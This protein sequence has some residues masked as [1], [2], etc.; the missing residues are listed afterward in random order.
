[1][2]GIT[3]K[4]YLDSKRVSLLKSQLKEG[5]PV[6]YAMYEAGY[7][8]SSRLY[9]KSSAQLGMTPAV[10]RK[11][12]DGMKIRFAI[13]DSPLGKLL[14]AATEIGICSVSL[15]DSEMALEHSLRQEY[16]EATIVR[17][18]NKLAPWI[19]SIV[20]HMKGIRTDL[21]LP[22]EVIGTAFQRRVWEE[23]RKIPLGE[24]RTYT[25]IA[26]AIG[27]PKAVRAV[28][29][30][31]GA[32]HAAIVIPCHRVVRNDGSLG[33]YKWGIERKEKLIA[34]ERK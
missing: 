22:L 15:G 18:Q 27:N 3:P 31:C 21:D 29:N 7:G 30:A 12:G 19:H 33:G 24:T 16:S 11:N 20:Q 8:S 25:Q 10:Y 17:D 34:S 14:V 28:A 23:L 2:L 1:V 32:N 5:K 6:S 4:Q 13:T 26:N 9:E